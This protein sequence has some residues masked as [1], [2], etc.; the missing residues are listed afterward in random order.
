MAM[1]FPMLVKLTFDGDWIDANGV[2]YFIPGDW[3]G[4]QEIVSDCGWWIGKVFIVQNDGC[5]FIDW[6]AAYSLRFDDE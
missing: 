5:R 1:R 2:R 4:E 6:L 3:V